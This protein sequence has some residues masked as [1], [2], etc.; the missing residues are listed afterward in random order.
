MHDPE[1]EK[2]DGGVPEAHNLLQALLPSALLLGQV[3]VMSEGNQGRD[4]R[5]KFFTKGA[6]LFVDLMARDDRGIW[7]AIEVNGKDHVEEKSPAEKKKAEC[8]EGWG[9]TIVELKWYQ[10]RPMPLEKWREQLRKKMNL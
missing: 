9:V 2:I 5:Y 6:D 8:L 10:G 3:P 7:H 1:S 4:L